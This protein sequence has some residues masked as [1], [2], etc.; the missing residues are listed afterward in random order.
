M[1]WHKAIQELPEYQRLEMYE[2]IF[3]YAQTGRMPDSVTGVN[4]SL[5]MVIC[6][7]IPDTPAEDTDLGIQE[8]SET[9]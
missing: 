7:R 2:A 6:D 9:E 1:I 5:L 8:E 4:R 3:E